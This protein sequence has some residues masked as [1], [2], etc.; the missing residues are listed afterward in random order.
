MDISEFINTDFKSFS[1]ADNIRNI[2]SICDGF[3]PSQ[4]K[5]I[6]TMMHK[7]R[8]WKVSRLASAVAEFTHYQHGETSLADT[9]ITMAQDYPGSNNCP[10]LLKHGQFGNSLD[11]SGA[12]APRYISVDLGKWYKEFF[13]RNDDD[14]LELQSIEGEDAEPFHLM[15]LIPMWAVNGSSGIGTGHATKIIPHRLSD[16][17]KVIKKYLK[18]GEDIIPMVPYI[19]GFGGNISLAD[20]RVTL[21]GV[22]KVVNTTHINITDIPYLYDNDSYKALLNNLI[23]SGDI[24]D[25]TNKSTEDGWMF[26]ISCPRTTTKKTK[27]QIIKLFGLQ[28]TLTQNFTLWDTNGLLHNYGTI[29][30]ALKEWIDW[31]LALVVKRKAL[32]MKQFKA[33]ILWSQ[34]QSDFVTWWNT[35]SASLVKLNASD[36]ISRIKGEVTPKR[37]FIELLM[38]KPIS[39]LTLESVM[40]FNKKIERHNFEM[41]ELDAKKPV[42]IFYDAL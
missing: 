17:K 23:I 33:E 7:D 4:R 26:E 6:Y 14:L 32:M 18:D 30:E 11:K 40:R 15:P 38:K 36:L 21:T 37:M 29:G 31:R 8:L 9:A 35:N 39:S 28:R 34:V 13:D 2:P 25:Y 22:Y 42:D 10:L 1:M 41:N 12:S 3:K 16:I 27:K 20:G 24:K 5:I 19:N